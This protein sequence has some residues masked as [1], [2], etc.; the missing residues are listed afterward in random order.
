[1]RHPGLSSTVAL[2]RLSTIVLLTALRNKDRCKLLPIMMNMPTA[3]P[4]RT[5]C[6]ALLTLGV[7][8]RRCR[9]SYT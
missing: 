6:G 2:G 9:R 4:T 8:S 3:A 7:A 1:M 5:I